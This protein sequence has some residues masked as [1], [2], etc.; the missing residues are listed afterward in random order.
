MSDKVSFTIFGISSDPEERTSPDTTTNPFVARVS[1]ATC[2]SWSWD[3]KLSN[4]AAAMAVGIYK[5]EKN[6]LNDVAAAVAVGL[7]K[8]DNL[9]GSNNIANDVADSSWITVNR[10]RMLL[11]RNRRN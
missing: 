9:L 2:D 5:I 7:Y 11:K 1:Q 10:S 3:N 4:I 6:N 8:K